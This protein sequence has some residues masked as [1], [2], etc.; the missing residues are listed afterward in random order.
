MKK[1]LL[2]ILILPSLL[3]G[4]S[5]DSR[6]EDCC[7]SDLSYE[8]QCGATYVS[9]EDFEKDCSPPCSDRKTGAESCAV[10][11]W[12]NTCD[13]ITKY[14]VILRVGGIQPSNPRINKIYGSSVEYEIEWV[15]NQCFCSLDAWINVNYLSKLGRAGDERTKTRLRI[16]PVSFG[17][18]RTFR[19]TDHFSLYAGLGAN[20]TFAQGNFFS[21]F[22]H[23]HKQ[24]WG[25][26]AKGGLIWNFCNGLFVDIFG[27]YYYTGLTSHGDTVN[28]GG[29]RGGIG[30]G[31]GY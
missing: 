25:F 12:I 17:I 4:D 9:C 21:D 2:S 31:I 10:F 26:V 7:Y 19:F 22:H 6:N 29:F 1:F 15:M 30:L 24:G 5:G 27:D 11:D 8:E 13:C 18:K 20:Y 14:A 3:I 16:L 23:E 28:I